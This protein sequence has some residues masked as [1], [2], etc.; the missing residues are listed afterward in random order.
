VYT[1]RGHPRAAA[2]VLSKVIVVNDR[3]LFSPAGPPES[4]SVIRWAG[5]RIAVGANPL[6]PSVDHLRSIAA[7][8]R[9][10]RHRGPRFTKLLEIPDPGTAS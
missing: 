9:A 8:P 3:N 10:A 7:D 2:K 5:R 1:V 4:P 6:P